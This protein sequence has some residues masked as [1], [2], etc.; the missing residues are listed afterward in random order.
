MAT[1]RLTLLLLLLIVRGRGRRHLREEEKRLLPAPT[2][3]TRHRLGLRGFAA[4]PA[5]VCR[6][7]GHTL[8]LERAVVPGSG[9]F[10]RQEVAWQEI[11]P[12]P[13]GG[14]HS[15]GPWSPQ[16]GSSEQNQPAS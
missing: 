3:K 11:Y 14:A 2:P 4:G 9:C 1:G 8:V 10:R 12:A 16:G 7:R 6:L 15:L 13:M 5:Q